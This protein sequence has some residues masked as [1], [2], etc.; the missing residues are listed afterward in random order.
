MSETDVRHSTSLP[1]THELPG[2]L[3]LRWGGE[4]EELLEE[5]L[6]RPLDHFLSRPGKQLRGKMVELGF[7]LASDDADDLS[8]GW[9]RLCKQ[10]AMVVEAIHAAS[11][12]IDDIQDDSLERRGE[13]TL[14]RTH[15]IPKALN[16]GNWLYFW[17][18]E[19][20]RDWDLPDRRRLLCYEV[21]HR[22]L[23][24]A[25]F[26]QAV[27]LGTPI[28]Q[29]SQEKIA[30]ISLASIEL[31]TG[32][33]MSLAISLGA[34]LGGA[35]GTRLEI[36]ESFG[37]AF[38]VAL[39]MFDDIGNVFVS[40]SK[41]YEDLLLRRPTW[42]W[43]VAAREYSAEDFTEFV[44]CVRRLPEPQPLEAWLKTKGFKGVAFNEAHFRL[45][46]AVSELENALKGAPGIKQPLNE[47]KALSDVLVK[48]YV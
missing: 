14:H 10:G 9:D 34:I 41:Q 48:S 36:L 7:R 27:D 40:G 3:G 35:Q 26:G 19:M 47:L 32:A 30:Q 18:L 46:G 45:K 42:V 16:A 4:I 6:L 44:K 20:M 1:G 29:Q 25:H 43:A 8:S 17:P 2:L 39:Q 33:L 23:L 22:A 13:P 31:K 12:V 37:Q 5:S 38:G 28:D 15:G 24:R 11:L 21:C